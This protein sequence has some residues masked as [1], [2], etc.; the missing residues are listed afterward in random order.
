[1][2]ATDWDEASTLLETADEP[3]EE[4]KVSP[5]IVKHKSGLIVPTKEKQDLGGDQSQHQ[6]QESAGI[7]GDLLKP[8]RHR[9]NHTSAALP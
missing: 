5:E 7:E 6:T 8:E 3:A 1:M 2:K 9:K 4:K